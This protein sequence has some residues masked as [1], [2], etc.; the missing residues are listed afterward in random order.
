MWNTPLK[1][2]TSGVVWVDS[3]TDIDELVAALEG[4]KLAR[5]AID[6][7]TTKQ[8]IIAAVGAALGFPQWAGTNLDA[9]YDLLTDLDWLDQAQSI[10]LVLEL[11]PKV[12]PEA[13]DGWR[14]IVQVV[15]DA[16][17]W[18]QPDP[19]QFLAVFARPVEPGQGSAT[20]AA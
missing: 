9:F 14:G 17:M 1:S 3:S 19:R 7:D 13:I 15:F 2:I 20:G 8:S 6:A 11:D 5:I 4:Y 16:A 12:D 10:A 18:W